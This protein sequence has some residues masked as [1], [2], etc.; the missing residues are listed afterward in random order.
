VPLGD[1]YLWRAVGYK[2]TDSNQFTLH[3]LLLGILS[4]VH[5]P[6]LSIMKMPHQQDS[7]SR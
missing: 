6:E 4:V 5:A 2:Q 3:W 7:R 1:V